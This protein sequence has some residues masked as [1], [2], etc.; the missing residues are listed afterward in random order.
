MIKQIVVAVITV[1]IAMIP[2][3]YISAY[4]YSDHRYLEKVMYHITITSAHDLSTRERHLQLAACSM[5]ALVQCQSE[6]AT[7]R[8]LCE[9][10]HDDN[11]PCEPN[12]STCLANCQ[13][14]ADCK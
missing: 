13:D 2:A 4:S 7:E 11:L 8:V 6:C 14:I 10:G 12:Y 1:V 5:S 3:G 9:T